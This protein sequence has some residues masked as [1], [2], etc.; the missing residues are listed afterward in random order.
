MINVEQ[1]RYC[2]NDYQS[3]GKGEHV[4]PYGLGGQNLYMDCVCNNCNNYF[5]SLERE[6]LQTSLIGLMRSVEGIQ[7]YKK[8]ERLAPF[9]AQIL[10]M[11]GRNKKIVYEVGQFHQMQV[12]VRP[13]IIFIETNFYLE[14]DSDQGRVKLFEQYKKWKTDNLR[15]IT[16]MPSKKGDE[17]E[18]VEFKQEGN[19]FS[20]TVKSEKIKIKDEILF[21]LLPE[22]HELNKVL[23][24]T[25]FIDDDGKLRVRAATQEGA[26]EFVSNFLTATLKQLILN[27]FGED[28]ISQPIIN[29]G[30]SFDSFKLE[31][32]LVKIGINCLINYF[33]QIRDE[34]CLNDSISFVMKGEPLIHR[35]VEEQKDGII[36]SC[37]NAH[38]IFFYQAED[39]VRVRISLFNGGFIFAFYVPQLKILNPGQYN[40]LVIN[41]QERVN[42]FEDQSAFFRS[43]DW[44]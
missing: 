18:Y 4:F 12:F 16:K 8:Y 27:S 28:D 41:Y 10:L 34:Q 11:P 9:K 32:S 35:E 44:R 31:Q 22:S 24:P 42:K 37:E 17:I 7:G 30:Y 25:L 1:C 23:T 33:P 21:D 36:D 39:T 3:N 40:R 2:G 15:M 6:L 26:I 19:K 5:S 13:Q 43:F 20:S 29:V 38:T 14:A